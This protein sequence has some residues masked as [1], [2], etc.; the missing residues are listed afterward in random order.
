M[1]RFAEVFSEEQIV[2][3]LMTQLSWTHFIYIIPI[4]DPL[5]REFYAEMCRLER[6]SVRTLQ[7]KIDGMLFE[8]TAIS[9]KPDD[10][11]RHELAN[12]RADDRLTPDLVFRDPYVLSRLPWLDRRLR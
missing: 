9:K 12:L 5:K 1:I 6:W 2:S 3:S 8:R 10:I 11:I 4:G 7:R